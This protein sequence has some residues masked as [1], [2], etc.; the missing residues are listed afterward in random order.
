VRRPHDDFLDAALDPD[1]RAS[2]LIVLRGG[3]STGK[4]RS[5]Y[6]A[7]CRGPLAAWRLEYPPIPAELARLLD[8]GVPPRTVIWLRELRD[9]ADA[10]GGQESLARLARL[11]AGSG[12]V[13]AITT[14][15]ERFWN[16]YSRDHRGGPGSRDPYLAARALLAGLPEVASVSEVN[17]GRG[18][19][20][21]VP[22]EFRESE[23]AQARRLPDPALAEAIAAAAHENKPL[24][25]IQYLAGVPDL[26]HHYEGPGAD[27]YARAVITTAMDVARVIGLRRCTP[28]FLHRAAVGYLADEHRVSAADDW[29]DTAIN[30][31]ATELRGAVRALTPEPHTQGTQVASYKLAD[32]LDQH[33]RKIF[34][35]TIPPPEFWAAAT[36]SK[37]DVQARFGAAAAD[38]GLLKTAAQLLKNA[39]E[40]DARAAVRLLGIMQPLHPADTRAA[41]WAAARADLTRP[42]GVAKLINTLHKAETHA[43]LEALLQ[44]DPAAYMD[45]SDLGGVSFLIEALHQAGAVAQVSAILARNPAANADTTN[46]EIFFL[47]DA[48]HEVGATE[49][50]ATLAERAVASDDA[51]SPSWTAG[52]L[53]TLHDIGADKQIAAL[54]ALNPAA[55]ADLTEPE[56][57]DAIHEL[58]TALHQVGADAQVTTLA[59]R[60]VANADPDDLD[61]T[62]SLLFTM[63]AVGREQLVRD[64]LRSDPVARVDPTKTFVVAGLLYSLRAVGADTEV[65]ALLARNPATHAD[66]ADPSAVEFLLEMF[67]EM[68]AHAQ[69]AALLAR[70]P[71]AHADQDDPLSV[72]GFRL[73][74]GADG[75]DAVSTALLD[76]LPGAGAFETFLSYSKLAKNYRFGRAHDGRPAAPWGWDDLE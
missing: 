29:C 35:E 24:R 66:L 57:L 23:L 6:H 16:A 43:Q 28:G 22:E 49:Q 65:S 13:I 70:D 64:L 10:E 58:I 34:A 50:A 48:L 12:R 38:R 51:T 52:L 15:W 67:H 74:L 41:A 54:L 27:P 26:L 11:L 25:V 4:S 63:H 61:S 53:T 44:R 68:G 56:P 19:V 17:P 71:A 32:Y 75:T 37:P 18:C 36:Q 55:H 33:G 30:T 45:M 47:L 5:A 8:E 2:R 39:T 69:V 7:V 20:I 62:S 73:A 76:R 40:A 14:T 3:P 59:E 72:I 1:I 46:G 21:D 9:Y 31:A 42:R 60:A